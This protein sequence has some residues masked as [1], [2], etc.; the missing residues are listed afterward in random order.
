MDCQFV[1]L[2]LSWECDRHQ[3]KKQRFQGDWHWS[4]GCW[5]K[6]IAEIIRREL[7]KDPRE[8]QECC[9]PCTCDG[10]GHIHEVVFHL[11]WQ[12]EVWWFQQGSIMSIQDEGKRISFSALV[13]WWTIANAILPYICHWMNSLQSVERCPILDRSVVNDIQVWP[14]FLKIAK[15]EAVGD[16]V[17][18]NIGH[19]E[20]LSQR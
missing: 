7:T 15:Q 20:W 6:E 8:T 19:I 16:T 5:T 1:L 18:Q 9:H 10:S 12:R 13:N 17:R 4:G 3:H 14:E 11:A 2:E